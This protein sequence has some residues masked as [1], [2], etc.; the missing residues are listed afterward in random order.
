[1]KHIIFLSLLGLITPVFAAFDYVQTE[2][3]DTGNNPGSGA[4][5]SDGSQTGGLTATEL[6]CMM[7]E[8]CCGEMPNRF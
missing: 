6:L 3:K 1:M 4:I 2:F 5:Q 7:C 8:H